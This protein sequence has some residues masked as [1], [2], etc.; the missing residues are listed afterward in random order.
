MENRSSRF[1][2]WKKAVILL[3]NGFVLASSCGPI[4]RVAATEI[5]E[6][7][8]AELSPEREEISF[9]DWL[10]SEFSD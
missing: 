9:G 3:A 1:V 2:G 5:I 10:A 7:A 4:L 6:A 8:A